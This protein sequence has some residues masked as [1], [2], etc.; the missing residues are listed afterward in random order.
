MT[1]FYSL[2]STVLN[3]KE[4]STLHAAYLFY[5]ASDAAF[6]QQSSGASSSTSSASEAVVATAMTEEQ[7]ALPP[8]QRGHLTGL[9]QEELDDERGVIRWEDEPQDVK[10]RLSA[11]LK[12]LITDVMVIAKREGFDVLNSLT[13]LD[14]NLFLND[15]HFGPGDGFL[16]WYLYNYN[17]K[18]IAGGMGGRP[19]E[20]ELDPAASSPQAR[21]WTKGSGLGVAMV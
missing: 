19:G 6:P 11:R 10:A 17:T 13:T 18:P 4:H 20:A 8:W 9:T 2:P 1:S 21:T 16:R 5:Y 7:R 3:S 12:S 15:L 14:N